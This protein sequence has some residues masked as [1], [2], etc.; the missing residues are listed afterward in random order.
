MSTSQTDTLNAS[1]AMTL[2]FEATWPNIQDCSLD[3][4]DKDAAWKCFLKTHY[5]MKYATSNRNGSLTESMVRQ[6]ISRLNARI[7]TDVTLG[8]A[9]E[10][11]ILSEGKGDELLPHETQGELDRIL[12]DLT[13]LAANM[14]ELVYV[15]GQTEIP[16][17]TIKLR[18]LQVQKILDVASPEI[19][20][21]HKPYWQY[22]GLEVREALKI[23]RGESEP[24]PPDNLVVRSRKDIMAKRTLVNSTNWEWWV[25]LYQFMA[26]QRKGQENYDPER[27]D[28]LA[29]FRLLAPYPPA[30]EYPPEDVVRDPR[31]PMTVPGK[32]DRDMRAMTEFFRN[33]H[34][35]WANPK[36]A[37]IDDWFIRFRQLEWSE[38]P[39]D[40]IIDGFLQSVKGH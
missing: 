2:L 18:I 16:Q 10:S 34:L 5:L 15:Y 22:I 40:G 4:T 9:I 38:E 28:E 33:R 12:Y 27:N 1:E 25:D 8:D 36:D 21:K 24:L 39:D 32:S 26:G 17:E 29:A 37:G 20:E 7:V 14:T 11:S 13:H 6:D 35:R 31:P 23:L 3:V 30:L 19:Q